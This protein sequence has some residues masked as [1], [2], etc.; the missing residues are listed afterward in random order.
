MPATTPNPTKT[1]A[2]V[3]GH[4]RDNTAP[5]LVKCDLN[6]EQRMLC[7]QWADDVEW[8]DVVTWVDKMVADFHV[9]SLKPIDG[10]GF[11]CSVTGQGSVT[12]GTHNGKCLMGRASSA[13]KAL[14]VC[15]Y[16]DTM[17][18]QGQ[19][20]AAAREADLEL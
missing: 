17:V 6:T 19:W 15:M 18:L 3:N 16:K 4:Q 20:T 14:L 2:N 11:Q 13:M 5:L 10:G 9:I 8:V 7:K 12:V 1:S